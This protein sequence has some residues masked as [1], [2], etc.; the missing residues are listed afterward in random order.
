MTK[1]R[2]IELCCPVCDNHFRSPAVE[3]ADSPYEKRTD[4]H[5]QPPGSASLTYIVHTCDRCEFAGAERDF[6]DDTELSATVVDH[7]WNELASLVADRSGVASAKYEAE[8]NVAEW[9]EDDSRHTT[10]LWLHAAWC[11]GDEGDV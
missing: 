5:E 6:T 3:A 9:R 1:R 4:S 10:D 7:V 2:L 8:A 11:C